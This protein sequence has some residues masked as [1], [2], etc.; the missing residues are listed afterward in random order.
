MIPLIW[1]LQ[2]L[3][4]FFHHRAF[5]GPRISYDS[6]DQLTVRPKYSFGP[7]IETVRSHQSISGIV[8]PVPQGSHLVDDS[9]LDSSHASNDSYKSRADT[10]S[11]SDIAAYCSALAVSV[12]IAGCGWSM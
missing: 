9:N 3:G 11:F 10:E 4:L 2:P 1:A 6:A 7:G 12:E 8:R 5:Y